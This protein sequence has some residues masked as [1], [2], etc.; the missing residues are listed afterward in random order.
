MNEEQKELAD[1]QV[2]MLNGLRQVRDL[3]REINKDQ[4]KLADKMKDLSEHSHLPALITMMESDMNLR[5][6][7]NK[8]NNK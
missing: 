2:E 4:L 1:F 7:L 8:V 3:L 6:L 5:F